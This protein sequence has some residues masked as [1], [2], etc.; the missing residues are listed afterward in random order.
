MTLTPPA[1]GRPRPSEVLTA[2][3]DRGR[4]ARDLVERLIA[5]PE[6][7]GPDFQPIRRLQSALPSTAPLVGWK[8]SARGERGTVAADAMQL[9]EQ[10][11]SVGLVERLD[12]AF[13]CH[14]F[15]VVI[16]AGLVGEL[17]LTPEP[18]TFGGACPPRL[19]VSWLRG[20]RALDVCAELHADAFADEARLLAAA[21]EMTGWG[22]H[23]VVADVSRHDV[24]EVAL[25]LL[26][27]LRPAY[28][29]LSTA[30]PALDADPV[31]RYLDAAAEAGARVIA[32]DVATQ[33]Q[34]DGAIAL[35]AAYGRGP[36]IG[37]VTNLPR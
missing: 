12:W 34:L 23:L 20:R 24:A 9:L 28:V 21:E 8:A 11:S 14:A 18:E 36:L 13:R 26:P 5:E 15:D 7:L 3:L 4:R 2:G 19:A 22:W 33:A 17:H 37:P 16:D 1:T 29:H 10:A 25:R 30:A 6:R 27:R 35:G 32:I 31:R